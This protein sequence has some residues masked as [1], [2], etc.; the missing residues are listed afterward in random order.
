MD[1]ASRLRPPLPALL[2][3]LVLALPSTA[4]ANEL[5][6]GAPASGFT[7]H[8]AASTLRDYCQWQGA[9]LVFTVPGGGSWELIPTTADP[10][11]TNPGDGRFHP[12]D[13]AEVRSALA[14][15][16]YPLARVSAEIFLLPYPRRDGL[17]SAAGPGLIL[18]SPGVLALPPAQQHA[19]FTHEL[20]HVVQFALMPDADAAA[21][22]SYRG[23]RG[24]GDVGT[25]CA[26]AAHADRPHEI[27]AEDFRALFGDAQANAAGTIENASLVYPTAIPGLATFVAALAGAP[28]VATPLVASAAAGGGAAFTRGGARA[29]VLDLFD[30]SGRRVAA[31]APAVDANGCRWTWDGRGPGGAP[32]RGA[33]LWA[34]ARDG[35]GGTARFVRL[36]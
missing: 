10:A 12:F 17:A 2:L 15:V 34:R 19:E 23:L 8:D 13:A 18:L 24:I 7:I 31:L 3:A 22:D 1:T 29:A 20:G 26:A 21:W 27:F 33:L 32:V 14:G 30:V 9:H 4:A 6:G 16:R 25:Y 35:A 36:P 28:A 5:T 11:I